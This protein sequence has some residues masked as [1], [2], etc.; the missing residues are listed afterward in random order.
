MR[1]TARGASSA[2]PSRRAAALSLG[3]VGM[4]PALIE[5]AVENVLG[6]AVLE[7]LDRAARDHPAT[8]APHAVFDQTILTVPQG[9]HHLH[10]LVRNL[11]ARDVACGL[12]NGALVSRRQAAVGVNSGAIEEKLRTL[13]LDRHIGELP[14]QAL[15]L[16]QRSAELL[17]RLRMFAC[18]VE[19]ITSQRKRARGVA[20][21]LD[22]EARHLL[23]EAARAEQQVIDRDAAIVE[24]QLAPF[25]TAHE[26]RR[27]PDVK[28]GCPALDDDGAD[29]ADAGPETEVNQENRRIAAEGGKDLT[30]V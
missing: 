28:A 8:A 4:A 13:E 14:L 1:A 5:A 6:N 19:G 26:S 29:A 21:A 10:G 24:M 15:K 23:F 18:P 30:A 27:L 11:E 2:L 12:G 7:D 9:A 3:S 25:F 16:A 22:V 20:D 17:A